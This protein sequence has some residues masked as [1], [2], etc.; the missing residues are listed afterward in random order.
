VDRLALGRIAGVGLATLAC[1]AG[2]AGAQSL[3]DRVLA[4]PAAGID[5]LVPSAPAA[6]APPEIPE[7]V[8]A[9]QHWRLDTAR[10]PVHVWIPAGYDAQTAAAV[11]FVHGYHIDIDTAWTAH[12][13]PE[14]FALSGLNAMFIAPAAPSGKRMALVW[15]SL[16]ELRRAVAAGVDVAMPA[17]RLVA[18]GHSGAYRTLAMWLGNPAL[19]T[20]ILLDAVYGEMRFQPWARGA[21]HRRLVNIAYETWRYSEWMH[22]GLPDTVR[23]D[24][25]PTDA[26]PVARVLLVR[27]DV[28]HF[29]LVTDGVAIPLALRAIGVPTVAQAPLDLPLGLPLR[30]EAPPYMFTLADLAR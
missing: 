20:V 4:T 6:L 13:L 24:A 10:G 1:L 8:R 28:G 19:D 3:T 26:L 17:S 30:C 5:L 2:V 21:P 18:V 29:P 22:R 15:P 14:Q 23:L 27:T 12:R 7:L 9:G 11:V 16:A 25:L